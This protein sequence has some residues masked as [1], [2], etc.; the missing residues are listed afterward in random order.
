[1]IS[2]S[3]ATINS[4]CQLFFILTAQ[5]HRT[6]S[7]HSQRRC[8]LRKFDK[9]AML[10]ASL[11]ISQTLIVVDQPQWTVT[12]SI[13]TPKVAHHACFTRSWTFVEGYGWRT[14]RQRLLSE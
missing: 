5:Q 8:L 4:W 9:K 13:C 12:S 1:M 14:G 7:Y 6:L 2:W 3:H 11:V 10:G